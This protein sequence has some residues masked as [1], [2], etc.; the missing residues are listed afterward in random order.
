MSR[1][2]DRS[3]HTSVTVSDTK[4]GLK[5]P[6]LIGAGVVAAAVIAAGGWRAL[7]LARLAPRRFCAVGGHSPALW[8]DGGDTAAGAF[9]DAADFDRHDLLRFARDRRLYREPVWIDVGR[10]DPFARADRTLANELRTNAT[11]VSFHVHAG[12]HSGSA[13]RMPTYLRW[14]AARLA[15]CRSR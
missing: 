7:D 4:N 15:G 5:R 6:W 13:T 8:F 3:R 10:D 1:K 14:Y 12:G 9:D 11:P 2:N